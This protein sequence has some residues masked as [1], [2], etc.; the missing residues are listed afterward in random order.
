[1]SKAG[2]RANPRLRPDER[3][4]I[5]ERT[6][7]FKGYFQVDRYRLRHRKFD[8][9]WTD[10]MAREIFERGHAAAVLLYD[11]KMDHVVLIEQFRLGAHTAGLEPWLIEVVAGIIDPGETAEAVVRR[12]AVEEA[13][14]EIT[15]L[16]PIG[17]FLATP[18][19]SSESLVIFCGRVDASKAGGIHGLDHEGEDIRVLPMSRAAAEQKLAE[20]AILNMTAVL[21]LQWL[22]LNYTELMRIWK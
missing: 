6:T 5:I 1:M 10:E 21:A 7:P 20:G 14:C 13:G 3:I 8:G 18:G 16:H 22:A 11:P 12:E 19:G 17:Q 4:E 2:D 15:A 9:G